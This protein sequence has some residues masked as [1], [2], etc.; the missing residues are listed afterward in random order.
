MNYRR[1]TK[2]KFNSRSFDTRRV[3][4]LET[5]YVFSSYQLY[6]I[7]PCRPTID[8]DKTAIQ[9]FRIDKAAENSPFSPRVSGERTRFGH[10]VKI[11]SGKC[12]MM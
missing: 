12:R 2:M 3:H 8:R 5:Y 7:I 10:M 6:N 9:C 4:Y 11:T 1:D